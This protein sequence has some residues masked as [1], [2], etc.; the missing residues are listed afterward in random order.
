MILQS[1]TIFSCADV[2]RRKMPLN[3]YYY[4]KLYCTTGIYSCIYTLCTISSYTQKTNNHT[5]THITTHTRTATVHTNKYILIFTIVP[6]YLYFSNSF[7]TEQNRE[8]PWTT[9]EGIYGNKKT[10]P[11]VVSIAHTLLLR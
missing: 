2:K 8:T 5:N 3:H 1:L 6:F 11:C 9:L 7:R 10:V 4:I